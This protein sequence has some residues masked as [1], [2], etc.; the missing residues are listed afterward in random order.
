[1]SNSV[2]QN[3]ER[4]LISPKPSTQKV[5]VHFFTNGGL[6]DRINLQGLLGRLISDPRTYHICA[7]PYHG[8]DYDARVYEH[9]PNEIW[10]V[11]EP[12][13]FAFQ[14]PFSVAVNVIETA[15][16][17]FPSAQ[18]RLSL[19]GKLNSEKHHTQIDTIDPFIFMTELNRNGEFSSYFVPD[20]KIQ[21]SLTK[22]LAVRGM[23]NRDVPIII[24]HAPTSGHPK[25]PDWHSMQRLAQKLKSSCNSM[26][27]LISDIDVLPDH[28]R[29]IFD[30][31][32]PNEKSMQVLFA[33]LSSSSLFI[34][35]DS[36]PTHLAAS[37]GIDIVQI[38]PISNDWLFGP[39]CNTSR[40]CVVEGTEIP[41]SGLSF[42]VDEAKNSAMRLI[43]SLPNQSTKHENHKIEDEFGISN[44]IDIANLFDSKTVSFALLNQNH[45]TDLDNT[46][47]LAARGYRIDLF[48]DNI[49][50]CA[51]SIELLSHFGSQS[52]RVIYRLPAGISRENLTNLVNLSDR[53]RD[54]LWFEIT[55][56]ALTDD[57]TRFLLDD[58]RQHSFV[59]SVPDDPLASKHEAEVNII[60]GYQCLLESGLIDFARRTRLLSPIPSCSAYAASLFERLEP[61][62][63]SPRYLFDN[64]SIYIDT[65]LKIYSDAGVSCSHYSFY[66]FNSQEELL[67]RFASRVLESCSFDCSHQC[68]HLNWADC[69][70]GRNFW[71]LRESGS[72]FIRVSNSQGMLYLAAS[73]EKSYDL[74][75]Y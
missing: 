25:Y 49:G 19:Y 64:L 54:L 24:F 55:P 48:T 8:D 60:E 43:Q 12:Y 16:R 72:K 22:H 52:H 66:S 34:G 4:I 73:C 2:P 35:G 51:Q 20:T 41:D 69:K 14:D 7:I 9:K 32:A 29:L 59:L 27:V 1:M 63:E 18:V 56:L 13:K 33:L 46:A 3:I 28:L 47:Y 57:L 37:A 38:R 10:I 31:M 36:G 17:L 11:S 44:L 39:Y 42:D 6:G 61:H 21:R 74:I 75:E 53:F 71:L 23:L 58:G 15:Q 50:H 5:I 68:K 40:L 26:N 45:A 67:G 30:Y 70:I 65:R 62:V